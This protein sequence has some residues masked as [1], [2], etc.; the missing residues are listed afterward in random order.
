MH[1]ESTDQVFGEV[2]ADII[3]DDHH[4]KEGNQGS[5][6]QAVNENDQAGLFQVPEFGMFDF[7]VDLG[8]GFFA[9]HRQYGMT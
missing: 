4:R 8:E 5:E 2:A 3:G 1:R 6:H 9:A 7:A